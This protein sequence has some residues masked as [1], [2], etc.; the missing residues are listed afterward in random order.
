MNPIA[1]RAIEAMVAPVVLITTTAILSGGIL[2]MY[3]SVNDRMRAMIR[4]R[5][6]S[7]T[8]DT[9]ALLSVTV[10]PAS[11]RE[12]LAQIDIQLPMLLN[13]HRLLKNAVLAIFAAIGVLVLSVIVIGA[14][15]TSG[16]GG[17]GVAALALVLAGTTTLLVG[18]SDGHP[19][20]RDVS[21]HDRLRGT[22]HAFAWVLISIVSEQRKGPLPKGFIFGPTDPGVAQCQY[23]RVENELV[24]IGFIG[25]T[26]RQRWRCHVAKFSHHNRLWGRLGIRTHELGPQGCR[27]CVR[28]MAR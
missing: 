19:V 12:R 3:G 10:L 20:Y 17:V 22:N 16:S 26:E 21:D 6:E 24:G 4:E 23:G 18:S 5:L 9:G 14:A 7:L 15:V 25:G 27:S 8:S 28:R 1:I 2:S 13:R 11:S